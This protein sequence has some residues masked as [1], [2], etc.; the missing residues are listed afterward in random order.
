VT[1]AACAALLAAAVLAPGCGGAAG[2]SN[3]PVT[4]YVSAPL[5]GDR[6]LQGNA[7]EDGAR[8]ALAGAHGGAGSVRLKAVYLDDSRGRAW[9]IVR[10]AANARRAAEDVS[11]IAYIGELDPAAT[12]ISLPITNQAE[13]AQIFPGGSGSEAIRS[14][15]GGGNSPRYQPSGEDTFVPVSA[16]SR[17]SAE[18]RGYL[19]MKQLIDAIR[20]AGPDGTDRSSVLDQLR[21]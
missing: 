19:A 13:I 10:T 6:A 12:R 11:T 18:A 8:R 5:T 15:P 16:P 14:I 9:N 7:V 4:V 3:G 2:R 21:G 1:R 17:A 20:R